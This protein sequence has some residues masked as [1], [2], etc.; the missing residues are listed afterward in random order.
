MSK[1][2]FSYNL[3]I[4][5]FTNL[6]VSFNHLEKQN[7]TSVKLSKTENYLVINKKYR[8]LLKFTQNNDKNSARI[9]VQCAEI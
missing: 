1:F 5:K 4:Y 2:Y 9:T 3:I 7:G 6:P 8:G